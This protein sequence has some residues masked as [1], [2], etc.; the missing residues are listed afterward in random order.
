MSEYRLDQLDSED[1]KQQDL[2]LDNTEPGEDLSDIT[3][4]CFTY[5]AIPLDELMTLDENGTPFS[6]K[7]LMEL[8]E[9]KD[10]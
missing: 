3:E 5:R 1:L 7:E 9:L 4:S 2:P 6:V 10:E 8:K